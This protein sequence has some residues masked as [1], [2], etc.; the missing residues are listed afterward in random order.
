M[1]RL[2][3]IFLF[4]TANFYSQK[5]V[6]KLYNFKL[7]EG[8]IIWQKI[9]NNT[10][11]TNLDKHIKSSEFLKPLTLIDS[12]FKGRSTN[13][14]KRVVRNNPYF[15][16]FGFD[17]FITIEFKENRYRVTAKDIVFDGPTINLYGVEEKQNY[18]LQLNVIKKGKIKNSKRFNNTL[19]KLD[20][21]LNSKFIVKTIKKDDW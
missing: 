14:K 10:T 11:F 1:K 16:T 18:P 21:I 9:Y 5:Y 6:D 3:F 2:L 4:F 17:A 19:Q 7:D 13:T 12:T 20:S 8:K 15:A